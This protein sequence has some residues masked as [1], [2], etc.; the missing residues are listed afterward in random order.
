MEKEGG[1]RGCSIEKCGRPSATAA[2]DDDDTDIYTDA[3]GCSSSWSS[4]FCRYCVCWEQGGRGERRRRKGRSR[5]RST[6]HSCRSSSSSIRYFEMTVASWYGTIFLLVCDDRCG[7]RYR[8]HWLLFAI[9]SVVLVEGSLYILYRRR[10]KTLLC[11]FL[12]LVLVEKYG[13][14]Q[15]EQTVIISSLMMIDASSSLP[16]S[17]HTQTDSD[18][19]DACYLLRG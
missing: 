16:L 7:Y 8:C 5:S 15:S 17:F 11:F 18:D 9:K 3:D 13:L 4:F 10:T 12:C 2:D 19:D 14:K 1:V 6:D